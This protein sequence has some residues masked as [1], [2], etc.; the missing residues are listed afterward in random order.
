MARSRNSSYR[1]SRRDVSTSHTIANRRLPRYLSPP[2]SIVPLSMFE[3]R[4]YFHPEGFQSPAAS[5][6]RPR[7]RLV[8]NAPALPRSGPLSRNLSVR[9]LSPRIAFA[10]PSKVLTCVR[11]QQRKEV[12][13]ALKK[14]GKVGQ[15]A[16]RK[17]YYSSIS[18]N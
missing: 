15:N 13:M 9:T 18:C 4:R 10:A 2:R 7:H 8:I 3:D 6:S 17:S 11:R 14:T 1:R 16:P 12:L 5:F